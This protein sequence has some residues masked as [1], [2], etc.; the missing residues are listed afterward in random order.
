MQRC[1]DLYYG[2]TINFGVHAHTFHYTKAPLPFH[3]HTFKILST[4]LSLRPSPYIDPSPSLYL[5]L[6]PSFKS[7]SLSSS[8]HISPSMH[9]VNQ[10]RYMQSVSYRGWR[11]WDFPPLS[12]SFTPQTLLT[13]AIYLYYFPT[14]RPLPYQQKWFCM[15]HCLWY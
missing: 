1:W 10:L 3:T 6:P 8:Y 2:S 13:S 14:P 15:K 7:F 4:P 12:S 11:T 9:C 5:S